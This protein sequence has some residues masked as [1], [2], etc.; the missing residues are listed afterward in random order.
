MTPALEVFQ[1]K[2]KTL[3]HKE[4]INKNKS[5]NLCK[6]YY[7]LFTFLNFF[8]LIVPIKI[9]SIFIVLFTTFFVPVNFTHFC[10]QLLL[11]LLL[12]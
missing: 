8:C 7:T 10:H 2:F 5:D 4:N 3:N 9:L 1:D 6:L 11:L 12:I